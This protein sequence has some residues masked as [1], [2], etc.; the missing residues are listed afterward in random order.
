MTMEI[1]PEREGSSHVRV[2]PFPFEVKKLRPTYYTCTNGPD[3]FQFNAP[4]TLRE[5]VL[6]LEGK[7]P[8]VCAF[9]LAVC[10]NHL[11]FLHADRFIDGV[12]SGDLTEETSNQS[13]KSR[14][15]N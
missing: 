7:P 9:V 12:Q 3:G 15:L 5:C 6:T 8:D 10:G 13:R 2:E 14:V 1:K 11:E 4:E